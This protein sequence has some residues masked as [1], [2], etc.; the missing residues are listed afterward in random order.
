M[1]KFY[2]W[3]LMIGIAVLLLGVLYL[4][5]MMPTTGGAAQSVTANVQ[6]APPGR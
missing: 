5:W 2:D 4:S 6:A 3:L 1:D